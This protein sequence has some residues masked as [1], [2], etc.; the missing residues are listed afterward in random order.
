MGLFCNMKSDVEDLQI[1]PQTITPDRSDME[2]L[3]SYTR[4]EGI[5][6]PLVNPV[7]YITDQLTLMFS[8]LCSLCAIS[9]SDFHIQ[10]PPK[11]FIYLTLS[12]STPL[13][14]TSVL[15]PLLLKLVGFVCQG[16]VK[17]C[18]NQTSV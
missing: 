13:I 17:L 12:I 10:R 18:V 3:L 14:F 1:F 11:S 15:I 7:P 4:Y 8:F 9:S 16:L 2:Q 6:F 5:S